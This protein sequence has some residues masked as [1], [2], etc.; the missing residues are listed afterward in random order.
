M[1]TEPTSITNWCKKLSELPNTVTEWQQS[2]SCP[3]CEFYHSGRCLN[4]ARSGNDSSCPFDGKPLP[5]REA[6]VEE[7]ADGPLKALDVAP[8]QGQDS[9]PSGTVLEKTIY[10]QIRSGTAGRVQALKVGLKGPKLVIGGRAPSY[11]VKQLA[12][13]S[14]LDVLGSPRD[15][16]VELC[17]DITVSPTAADSE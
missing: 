4:L 11:Y 2:I 16:D 13:K 8:C 6:P 14:A 9:P 7:L 10:R 3:D 12:L 15:S 17:L 5:Q 1:N